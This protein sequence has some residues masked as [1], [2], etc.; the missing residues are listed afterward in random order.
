MALS[1]SNFSVIE[2]GVVGDMRYVVATMTGDS[3]YA[4]GGSVVTPAMLGF[5][6]GI[7]MLCVGGPSAGSRIWAPLKQSD[8]TFK[9]KLFSSLSTEVANLANDSA[10]SYHIFALGR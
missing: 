4:T 10:N 3:S 6:T 7:L 1:V 5:T 9:L 8:G 2:N